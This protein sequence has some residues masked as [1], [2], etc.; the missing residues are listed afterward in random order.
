MSKK[1]TAMAYR[2]I[3]VELLYFTKTGNELVSA[4]SIKLI[5]LQLIQIHLFGFCSTCY[6]IKNTK[7]QICWS[8]KLSLFHIN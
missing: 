8:L 4:L 2:L 1:R 7:Q 6:I 3:I 5:H